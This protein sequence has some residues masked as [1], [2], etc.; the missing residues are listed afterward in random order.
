MPILYGEHSPDAE[1]RMRR[2]KAVLG[3]STGHQ[4]PSWECLVC[5]A[6]LR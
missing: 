3:I 6:R 1:E 5:G 2:G 4:R